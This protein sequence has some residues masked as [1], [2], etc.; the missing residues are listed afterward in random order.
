MTSDLSIREDKK[1]NISAN[2][3]FDDDEKSG[4]PLESRSVVAYKQAPHTVLPLSLADS[5]QGHPYFLR[6]GPVPIILRHQFTN[7][8]ARPHHPLYSYR[9]P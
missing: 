8:T 7:A 5:I 1:L 2:E 6:R 4:Q 3:E 9:T